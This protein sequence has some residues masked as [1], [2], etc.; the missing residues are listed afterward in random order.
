MCSIVG[1]KSYDWTAIRAHY[2]AGYSRTE[3][4]AK[5]GFSNGAWNR[6]VG[7]GE[8]RPRPRTAGERAAGKRAAIAKLREEGRS[9]SD[10]A[11]ILGISKAT[12]AYHAR[13]M[14]IPVDE[15]A[16]RRYDWRVIAEAYNSGLS[17]RECAERFGFCMASWADA[18]RRGDVLPRP[19]EMPIEELLVVGRE[20]TSRGHLKARLIKAGLKT[21]ACERCGLTDWFGERLGL[22]LHHING[23][24]RDN[25]LDNLQILCPNCHSQTDS[26][27]GRNGHRRRRRGVAVMKTAAQG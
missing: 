6:A 16:A 15:R 5:F 27:G 11:Q 1:G 10:I 26:W 17:V 23:N 22:E 20:Q 18:V 13:R 12:V 9:Y 25:R 4:Q 14:G 2:D 8:I 21:E 7:R 24:G 3:C 19:Q